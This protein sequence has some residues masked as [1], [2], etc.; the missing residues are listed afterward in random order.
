VNIL[1]IHPVHP[2]TPHISAVRA[3]RFAKELA[4]FGHRVLLLT[5]SRQGQPTA[6]IDALAD[7]DWQQPFILAYDIASEEAELYTRLPKSLRKAHTAWRMLRRGGK[8]NGWIASAVG[9]A[10]GLGDRFVPDVVWCTFGQMEA[11][12][13]AKRIASGAG[14]PW[15]LDIKDNWEL[16]VPHGLRRLMTWRTRGW[17]ALTANARFTAEK[18]RLW[19]GSEG[20]VV[21]SGVDESFFAREPDIDESQETF[22][23]NLIGS[24]YF[25][26]RLESFLIGLRGWADSLAPE[27]RSRIVVRYLGGDEALVGA[28]AQHCIPDIEI[29]CKGY[30]AASRMARYGRS[31]A[32]NVYIAH[33]GTFHHKL[34]ELLACGRPVMACPAESDESRALARQVSGVLLEASNSAQ[35]SSELTKLHLSWLSAPGQAA[36]PDPVRRYSWANQATVLEKTL[37]NV[38]SSS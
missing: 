27:Q 2:A 25:K 13:A 6:S 33:P 31:A 15:V 12:F 11:V 38:V 19:Q 36:S 24:V 35:V 4:S 3:W 20:T 16:Y 9:G 30:V 7:H 34:L 1:I 22:C 21:Y 29:K 26:E 14:C 23:I 18:A 10:R 32:V 28:V 37:A 8:L 5:A 17:A